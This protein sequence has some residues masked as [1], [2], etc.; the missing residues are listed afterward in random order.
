[1][2]GQAAPELDAWLQYGVLGLVLA[3]VVLGWLV[4]GPS[5]KRETERA[6]R[7]EV[8]LRTLRERTEERVIP[9]VT[10]ALDLIERP[11]EG[12]DRWR[13]RAAVDTLERDLEREP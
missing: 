4:P 1:M 5:H 3:A 7:L 10:R 12:G 2:L 13:D 11:R 8:E 9:L 6:D